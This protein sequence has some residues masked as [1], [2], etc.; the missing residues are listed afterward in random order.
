[1][2]MEVFQSS[3]VVFILWVCVLH[4]YAIEYFLATKRKVFRMDFNTMREGIRLEGMFGKN[5]NS[6]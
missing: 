1:M 4:F 3:N 6:E 2:S 5:Q